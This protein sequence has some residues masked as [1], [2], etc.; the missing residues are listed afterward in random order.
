MVSESG[1][2]RPLLVGFIPVPSGVAINAGSCGVSRAGAWPF[3]RGERCFK[4]TELPDPER[5]VDFSL[6]EK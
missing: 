5:P 6:H 1:F 2:R 3:R 4:T